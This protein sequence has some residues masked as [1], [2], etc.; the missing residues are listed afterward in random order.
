VPNITNVASPIILISY[1]RSGSSLLSKIFEL[2]PDFAFVGET[3]NFIFDLWKA[4]E[5]SAGRLAPSIEGKRWV[6]DDERAGRMV[7]EA[8]LSCFPEDKKHWFHKPIGVPIALS[9]K[10]SLDEWEKAA[11][12]YW[13]VMKS[14]FPN[15][16]YFTILRHPFDVILSAKSYWGFD[17]GEIW[18]N[19]ALMSYL[20]LHPSSPI[21]YALS[22]DEMVSDPENSVKSLFNFLNIPFHDGIIE[23][24][25]TVH[26]SSKGREQ[27][28]CGGFNRRNEWTQLKTDEINPNYFQIIIDFFAKYKKS[29]EIP[30]HIYDNIR[31]RTNEIPMTV[32]SNAR[33]QNDAFHEIISGYNKKI[34]QIHAEYGA[35]IIKRE[36]EFYELFSKNQIWMA[37]LSEAKAWLTSQNEGLKKFVEDLNKGTDWLQSEIC[38]RDDLIREMREHQQ[39]L[40]KA[41]D[42]SEQSSEALLNAT[43]PQSKNQTG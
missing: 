3:G 27:I 23:A 7:R 12:W 20:L 22:Y 38:K 31:H 42:D 32:D 41:L 4:Y 15:A 28:T 21:E 16:K 13:N 17:E 5:F 36:G 2:H 33:P 10:F 29:I 37:E 11:V 30:D 25:S 9:S 34:E 18:W 8:F 14:T 26:A 24:F 39:N 19:Y 6:P 40:K 1:G 43:D 35:K